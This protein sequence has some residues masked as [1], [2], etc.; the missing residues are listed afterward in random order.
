MY[1][2]IR[3]NQRVLRLTLIMLTLKRVL[4]YHICVQI[5]YTKRN[6]GEKKL[7]LKK[8]QNTLTKVSRS[9]NL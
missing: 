4:T 2:E 6:V 7:K 8:K 1:K 9:Y 3:I 5:S